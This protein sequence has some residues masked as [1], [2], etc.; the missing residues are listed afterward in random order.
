M[1]ESKYIEVILIKLVA[2]L[3]SKSIALKSRRLFFECQRKLSFYE[4]FGAD[5]GIF[6]L[7]LLDR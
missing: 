2:K 3:L 5:C 7:L 1:R 4:C 6:R